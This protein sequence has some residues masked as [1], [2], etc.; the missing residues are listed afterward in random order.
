VSK[1]DALK[2][3]YKRICGL[4]W[5]RNVAGAQRVW[6]AIYDKEDERRLR[7]R[8][9]LFEEATLATG[10]CWRHLDLTDAFANWLCSPPYDGFAESY[11]AAPTKLP[12]S[13]LAHFKQTVA[14]SIHAA[15]DDLE[16]PEESVVALSGVASLF[17]FVKISE[18]LPL[19]EGRIPGRLLVF[20]PGVYENHNYRLLDARDGWNYHAVPI[21]AHDGGSRG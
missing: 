15:F 14:D 1:I 20:F 2:N 16:A 10:Q 6:L 11:F 9:G 18:V 19:V 5:E 21:T 8:L 17:G 12:Q 7:L 4:P 3:N 13:A